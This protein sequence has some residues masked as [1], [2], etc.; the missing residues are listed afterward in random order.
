MW[1]RVLLCLLVI[2]FCTLL[3]YFAA[4]RYRSRKNFF[5]QMYDFNERYINELDYARRPLKE[6]VNSLGNGGEFGALI[7][8]YARTRTCGAKFT[9]LSEEE[10]DACEG[11]LKML[12]TGDSYSQKIFF[13]SQKK[14]LDERRIA[15][16]KELKERGG[17]YLK[18]G[19]LGG[20]AFVI[21]II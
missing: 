11:Y 9:F 10:K 4:S 15:A 13:S 2:L 5:V 8:E 3:G 7:G 1:I 20:L 19:F 17:L 12:G 18:L 16:E 6:I 14:L 21:L